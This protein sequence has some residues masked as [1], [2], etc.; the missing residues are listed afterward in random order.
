MNIN[1]Y[2]QSGGLLTQAFE[3][4]KKAL[5]EE[6]QVHWEQ[7]AFP[8]W[9]T[10]SGK[11][12]S[13]YPDYFDISLYRHCM[14]VSTI[15]F[16]LFLHTWQ[17]KQLPSIDTQ[18][19]YI[20]PN[21]ELEAKQALRQLFAIAFLHDA[22]KYYGEKSQ[23]PTP[24]QVER[25]YQEIK[26]FQ[27]CH[28]TA[29]ECY[30]GVSIVEERG[31]DFLAPEISP[32]LMKVSKMVREGDKL[33]S[34]ASREGGNSIHTMLKALIN[35]Y[36]KRLPV[37]SQ[38][39]FVPE[40]SLGLFEFRQSPI[41]LHS[42]AQ[43]FLDRLYELKQFPLVCLL[44]GERFYI[45]L[46]I[47]SAN[48][49]IKK[50]FYDTE[51]ILSGNKPSI[52]R[53]NT[54]G[55]VTL[56]HID[57]AATLIKTLTDTPEVG[58]LTVEAADWDS[59]N[60]YITN[61]VAA[62]GELIAC[63]KPTTGKLWLAI[64]PQRLPGETH[65]DLPRRYLW[66]LSIA[67]ALRA[68]REEKITLNAL[69][70][71]RLTRLHEWYPRIQTVLTEAPNHFV[72]SHF[73]T[74]TQQTLFALQAATE[75][76]N[77]SEYT[78]EELVAWLYGDFPVLAEKDAGAQAIMTVLKI[79]QGFIS[80]NQT[81][82]VYAPAPK[83][84][85]CLL[86][87]TPATEVLTDNIK[88][89]KKLKCSAFN[90][91]IGQRKSIWT[92]YGNNYLCPA[93]I[94][95]QSLLYE[96]FEAHKKPANDK[97]LL[98]ATPFRGLIK[99]VAIG[100]D[101]EGTISVSQ[102]LMFPCHQSP[103]FHH[104]K[105]ILPWHL[106]MSD[107]LPL[108]FETTELDFKSILETMHCMAQVAVYSG[109]PMHI[110]MSAQR[111]S[112]AAFVFEPTPPLI[113]TL[114]ADL[115]LSNEPNTVR[116]D[117]LPGLVERLGLF[118][119]IMN[120]NNGHDVLSA[121]PAYQWWAVAWL[122]SRLIAQGKFY[123]SSYV[124]LAQMVYPMNADTQIEQIAQ[125]AA[126]VQRHPGFK[127]SHN[128]RVFALTTALAQYDTGKKYRQSE[129][130]TVAAMAEH[131]ATALSRREMFAKGEGGFTARCQSFAQAVYNYVDNHQQKNAFDA[132][133]Q[134]FFLAA[135]AF[136]FMEVSR[137]KHKYTPENEE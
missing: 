33:T 111:D 34:I 62:V 82:P 112:K 17:A 95:Q 19:E 75:M 46:P 137:C 36:N 65:E 70:K 108:L 94:K 79:Q 80:D 90:N 100:A 53:K 55:E 26:V 125:L 64:K 132:R 25:L 44:N 113:R 122:N 1:R 78:L 126:G 104:W 35:H 45:S 134:R 77:N 58:L 16:L 27:W 49:L 52:N 73:G 24:E 116:R 10:C 136:L 127:A 47:E 31:L 93:C 123:F 103:D 97:P 9:L 42:L 86:C 72:L 110:F 18:G 37:F 15:A 2:L 76:V 11:G 98:I 96:T 68:K 107:S 118:R 101:G 133:F 91:R 74:N 38:N 39:Y 20:D 69:L 67:T 48:A 81:T 5:D 59:V 13:D 120:N 51:Q 128:E 40:E 63:D 105:N 3:P 131:L 30:T 89:P 71:M 92:Q 22:D 28:L 121:M 56:L 60:G 57:S 135:Y 66:A 23:S 50:V 6:A 7:Q 130:V 14:D 32:L 114:L 87:G 85:T 109:N 4:L 21:N 102:Q 119:Q 99:P 88:K 12:G 61:W 54:S 84:G 106:D 129:R 8:R 29:K 124:T 115:S 117:N 43:Q 83:G 41:V